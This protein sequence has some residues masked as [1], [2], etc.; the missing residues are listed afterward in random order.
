MIP[1][2][3]E[4]LKH[5]SDSK[6]RSNIDP[7]DV[8]DDQRNTIYK[9]TGSQHV[10]IDEYYP[11]VKV[12]R[13]SQLQINIY[14]KQEIIPFFNNLVSAM[15]II[16]AKTNLVICLNSTFNV[17]LWFSIL[18]CQLVVWLSLPKP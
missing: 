8:S 12:E 7:V 6:Q 4:N 15:K 17:L 16:H 13:M 5:V 11:R 14:C 3:S 10:D 18:C 1:A 9:M 2:T